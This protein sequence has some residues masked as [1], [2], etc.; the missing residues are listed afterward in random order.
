[1]TLELYNF[2]ASTCSL[3]VRLC[4]AE[5]DLD[6][7]DHKLM[8]GGTDHLTPEYLK[9][10]PNGV[11]PTLLHNGAPIIDSSVIIE[12]LDEVFPDVKLTP[13]DPKERAR[14]RWWLRYFEE[15]PTG[16]VRYPTFQKILIKNFRDMSDEEFKVA[17]EKRPLKTEFY[18]RMGRDGFSD[19][20][21]QTALDDIRQ[22]VERMH[23]AIKETGGPWIMG[24]FYSLADICVAP[25]IDRMEDMGYEQLWEKDLPQV[26]EWLARMKARPAYSKAYYPGARYSE[27]FPDLE[28]GRSA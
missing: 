25:L 20:E 26:T 19:A 21:I 8:P 10:N 24:D 7:V 18:T 6:W 27:I 1:M 4:L 13:D 17:A 9:I 23:Q 5:K 15:K 14:M 22:T 28:L 12:Y 16:A 3:K 11:V 2:P